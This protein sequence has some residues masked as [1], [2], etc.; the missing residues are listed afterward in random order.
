MKINLVALLGMLALVSVVRADSANNGIV[1]SGVMGPY[2]DASGQ[3][4]TRIYWAATNGTKNEVVVDVGQG[5]VVIGGGAFVGN[6]PAYELGSGGLLTASYPYIDDEWYDAKTGN[7]EPYARSWC[8][9]S[10]SNTGA[11]HD[12]FVQVIGMKL[13]K[14]S[15][16]GSYMGSAE[17][18]KYMRYRYE[19]SSYTAHPSVTVASTPGF[20]MVSGGGCVVDFNGTTLNYLTESVGVFSTGVYGLGGWRASSKDHGVSSPSCVVAYSI[21]LVDNNGLDMLGSGAIPAFGNFNV[22][23]RDV[24]KNTVLHAAPNVIPVMNPLS[25]ATAANN[26]GAV[27]PNLPDYNVI[28][29]TNV[30]NLPYV[31]TMFGKSIT[32]SL[33]SVGGRSMYNSYGRMLTALWVGDGNHNAV[34]RDKDQTYPDG[35]ALYG[36]AVYIIKDSGEGLW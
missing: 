12:L 22:L 15:P 16:Y 36:Q 30:T 18:L 5:E 3:I 21:S 8:A 17:L 34:V 29:Y 24:T 31:D 10:N 7:Y 2:Y 23:I 28:Q 33:V 19:I 27:R 25:V 20:T 13:K 6:D 26:A 1:A 32:W 35:G 9:R 11:T 14:N 4:E